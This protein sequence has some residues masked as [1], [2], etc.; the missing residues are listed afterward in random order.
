MVMVC[1]VFQFSEVNVSC[2]ALKLPSVVSD[3]LS[4]KV[5]FAVGCVINTKLILAVSTYS[6][7]CIS[8]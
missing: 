6:V 3:K 8:V 1:S 7:V 4:S 5:T 2:V